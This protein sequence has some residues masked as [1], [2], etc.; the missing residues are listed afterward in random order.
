MS[1]KRCRRGLPTA[2]PCSKGTPGCTVEHY[3]AETSPLETRTLDQIERAIGFLSAPDRERIIERLGYTDAEI[4]AYFSA[5][6]EAALP[7]LQPR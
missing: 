4:A 1:T 3:A 6:G 2:P 5:R 7:C